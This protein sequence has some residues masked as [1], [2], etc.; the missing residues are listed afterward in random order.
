MGVCITLKLIAMSVEKA[1][2]SWAH[3]YDT[4]INRTRDLNKK[5]TI[6]SLNKFE[7]KHGAVSIIL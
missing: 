4:N 5:C 2:N 6:E 7:F 1:Y 3:Q